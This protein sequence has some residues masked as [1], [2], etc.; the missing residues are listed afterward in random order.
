[1]AVPR[2]N[3]WYDSRPWDQEG[4][5]S[6][7]W[8]KQGNDYIY[9]SVKTYGMRRFAGSNED[10][11]DPYEVCLPLP[12][13]TVS[14]TV[15][16]NYIKFTLEEGIQQACGFDS[17]NGNEPVKPTDAMR[18]DLGCKG[19]AATRTGKMRNDTLTL[20][21]KVRANCS[22]KIYQ[23]ARLTT[24]RYKNKSGI[25]VREA[26]LG[27]S[28][29]PYAPW[30]QIHKMT[31]TINIAEN[32]KLNNMT[33]AEFAKNFI[34]CNGWCVDGTLNYTPTE[35]GYSMML[36]FLYKTFNLNPDD[37]CR[38]KID[39][40]LEAERQ[41]V[42]ELKRAEEKR[43]AEERERE[44]MAQFAAFIT[45]KD[46]HMTFAGI[47][48]TGTVEEFCEKLE[49]AGFKDMNNNRKYYHG[50]LLFYDNCYI[51][52]SVK[53]KQ[54]NQVEVSF[55]PDV[56]SEC[57]QLK[58]LYSS[59]SVL[60]KKQFGDPIVDKYGVKD[61]EDVNPFEVTSEYRPSQRY[62]IYYEF[63]QGTLELL[64]TRSYHT[65]NDYIVMRIKDGNSFKKKYRQKSC[66]E[67]WPA[68]P[69][70]QQPRKG[71]LLKSLLF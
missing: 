66:E 34:L 26:T 33:K 1:M 48:I 64:F 37:I 57:D 71:G 70:Q 6:K 4:K 18:E 24:R 20:K 30:Q 41:R 9:H 8:S 65:K 16:Q 53:K 67:V 44:F 63:P 11:S 51:T 59:I 25:Y 19:G 35:E 7:V 54:V 13:T 42:E 10:Y 50:E 27:T 22:H 21:V 36:Y 2:N 28:G 12:Y 45:P 60:L 56:Y 5:V 17:D 58:E 68:F 46:G 47:P 62:A 32:A 43:I 31:S 40:R 14:F 23:A 39:E 55:S 52:Y 49:A 29:D 38:D 61:F 15:N 3:C 69:V